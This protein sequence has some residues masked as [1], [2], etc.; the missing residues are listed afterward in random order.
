[1]NPIELLQKHLGAKAFGFIKVQD[2]FQLNF[3]AFSA[4]LKQSSVIERR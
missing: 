3:H 4:V 2:H 1:M